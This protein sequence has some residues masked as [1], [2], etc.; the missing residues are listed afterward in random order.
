MKMLRADLL[1]LMF[2]FLIIASACGGRENRDKSKTGENKSI[3]IDVSISG[4]TC[5]G[6]EQTIQAGVG[7][8]DGVEAVKADHVAGK[9]V[10]EFNPLKTDT[11]AIRDAIIRSG[12]KV[13]AFS[14]SRSNIPAE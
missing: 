10:V 7:K 13:T 14:P 9:A 3:T 4:M 6:C 11:S 8:I 12:Y 1:K 5:T 2:V